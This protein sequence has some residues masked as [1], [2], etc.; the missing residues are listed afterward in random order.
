VRA[1]NLYINRGTTGAVVLRQPFGGQGRSVFGPGLKA[2]G[3]NY[4]AQFLKFGDGPAPALPDEPVLHADLD[5]LSAQL[6]R[7]GEDIPLDEA[8]R[9]QSALRSYAGW[10][11]DEFSRTH[12]HFRLLGQDNLR[13]Y[14]PWE[15]IRVRVS[16]RDTAFETCA[17][18]AA[19]RV[20]GARVIVSLPPGGATRTLDLLERATKAWEEG[21]TFVEETDAEVAAMIRTLPVHAPERLRYAAP[22]RVP[23]MIRAAAAESAVSLAD[24][25]VVAHGRV[26]LLWYLREQSVCWDY[27]RYGNLGARAGESRGEPA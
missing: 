19:A 12:D 8:A 11:R 27:H 13:R 5:S 26:E 10:W 25:S 22:D 23:P 6:A 18:V 3:P 16:D 15:T 24:E 7:L 21:I 14:L 9:L 4:V 20:T 1:G 17:R 2:G